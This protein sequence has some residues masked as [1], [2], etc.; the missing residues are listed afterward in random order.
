MVPRVQ[1]VRVCRG[2][3]TL[4]GVEL[5]ADEAAVD[6][7]GRKRDR[8]TRGR[9]VE[10]ERGAVNG[11]EVGAL[12]SHHL[13]VPLEVR[14]L[15]AAVEG[16]VFVFVVVVCSGGG[17]GRSRRGRR[18]RSNLFLRLRGSG[19]GS[20]R[21]LRGPPLGPLCHGGHRRGLGLL[22]GAQPPPLALGLRSQR[23][24][25]RPDGVRG[26]RLA[27]RA[28]GPRPRGLSGPLRGLPPVLPGDPFLGGGHAPLR[29]GRL[30]R[31]RQRGLVG[32]S[33]ASLSDSPG[34]LR[35]LLCCCFRCFLRCCCCYCCAALGASSRGLCLGFGSLSSLGGGVGLVVRC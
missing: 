6:V 32:P 7:G 11:V 18:R 10:V 17:G 30:G 24:G 1:R 23:S 9:E 5:S 28:G 31:S 35:R 3:R 8:A 25:L 20:G 29:G 27:L 15:V 16:G 21:P 4:A 33:S 13:P 14:L 34:A 22:G 12:G 2:L 26:E 19:S